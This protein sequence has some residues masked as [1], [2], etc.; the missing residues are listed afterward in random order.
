L[1]TVPSFEELIA[2][3]A[4]AEFYRNY[5]EREVLFL[6]AQDPSKFPGLLT[7]AD[8]DAYLCRS[9]LRYPALRL[10]KS[11]E[12]IPVESYTTAFSLGGVK[13]T[14]LIR[15]DRVFAH[16]REGA[17]ILIQLAHWSLP[18]LQPLAAQLEKFFSFN[19]EMNVYLTPPGSQG[20]TAHFDTHSVVVLQLAGTKTWELHGDRPVQ[21]LLEDR[22]DGNTEQAG[23]V[24]KTVELTP[25]SLLYVPRGRFHSARA[26]AEP[27]LHVTIGLFPPTW[28][29]L[30]HQRLAQ[31]KENPR[32]RRAP[33]HDD[34]GELRELLEAFA[35]DFQ[36]P[37]VRSALSWSKLANEGQPALGRLFDTLALPDLSMKTWLRV[38]HEANIGFE[39][40]GGRLSLRGIGAELSLPLQ[41]ETFVRQVMKTPGDFQLDSVA[42]ELDA[43]S[44]LVVAKAMLREGV[45]AVSGPGSGSSCVR[46]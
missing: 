44:V 3:V 4:L 37:A 46:Q 32:F 20:F 18:S 35:H 23:E 21:P 31:M 10:V 36:L 8:L 2:P 1:S 38:R 11:G 13:A 22:F 19:V 45:L 16:Y 5:W 43:A 26:N 28:L 25:G 39:S 30:F 24:T 14:D 9:D 34:V 7:M 27:S 6:P 15:S 42:G 12:Q 33:T 17:T 40:R 29:D 41:A